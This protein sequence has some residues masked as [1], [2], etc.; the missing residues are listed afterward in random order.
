MKKIIFVFVFLFISELALCQL[1]PS[2]LVI[3]HGLPI[4]CDSAVLFDWNDCNGALS[5]G[6]QVFGGATTLISVSGLLLSEYTAPPHT[7]TPNSTYYCRIN[8]TYPAGTSP[9]SQIFNFGTAPLPS[10]PPILLYPADSAEF[11]SLTPVL[12]WSDVQYAASYRLQISTLPAFTSNVLDISGL[13]NSGYV[14]TTSILTICKRYYWRVNASNAGGTSP[15]SQIRTFTTACP[16]GV[17]QI[18]SEIPA[19]YKLYNNYPNPFNPS[20]YIRYRITNNKYTTLKIFDALGREVKILV[21]EFQKAG[22]YEISFDA[23]DM[24]SGLYFCRLV[25]GDFSD[26][27]RIML[28]K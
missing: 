8:A 12:D 27:K 25:S 9:W 15:W 21:N 1:P 11:I 17:K 10:N 26:T 20:T 2:Q 22:T 19:E 24:P 13:S 7:F 18:S 4:N 5:Y 14:I 23:G 3:N 6:F 16:A 28:I